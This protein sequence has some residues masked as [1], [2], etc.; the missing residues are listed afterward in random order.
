MKKRTKGFT[1]IELI[2]TLAIT[3]VVLGA[4][5]TFFITS[6]K[7]LA[8]TEV[9]SEMQGEAEGI[10]RVLLVIGTDGTGISKVIDETDATLEKYTEAFTETDIENNKRLKVKLLE[11]ALEDGSIC[12]LEYDSTTK[13]LSS[14]IGSGIKQVLSRNVQEFS[15]R[16]LDIRMK[17]LSDDPAFANSTGLEFS[18][19]L[20]KK[21]G[22]SEVDYPISIITKFRNK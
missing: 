20:N 5:Y 16:P 13:I 6:S 11:I 7:R 17:K 8:T 18:I 4:V 1:L 12:T 14:K 22:Y 2:I 21:K 3:T 15:I 10:Q 9:R 19:N